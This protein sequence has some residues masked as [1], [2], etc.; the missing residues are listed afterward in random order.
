MEANTW[1]LQHVE[2]NACW[3]TKLL[4]LTKMLVHVCS[5]KAEANEECHIMNK[6]VNNG[7]IE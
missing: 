7:K 4:A 2:A 6:G 3:V 1:E 5:L